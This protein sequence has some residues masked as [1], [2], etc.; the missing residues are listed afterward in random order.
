MSA[1]RDANT[2]GLNL[3]G[4]GVSTDDRGFV[5]IDEFCR[6]PQ[7]GVY[8]V[9]EVNG[10]LNR[11]GEGVYQGRAAV[12]HSV[13]ED[14]EL[15]DEL[16]PGDLYDPGDLNGRSDGGAC[17]RL[18]LPCR[19]GVVEFRDLL[20]SQPRGNTSG[21]LKLVFHL[22]D[23]RLLGVDVIGEGAAAFISAP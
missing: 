20:A 13:G 18:E 11:V 2:D 23:Y 15:L 22:P 3:E 7:E 5:I 16:P 21:M 19:V 4:V 6:T 14:L 9:G 10:S 1:G 12:L 17:Q 8:A